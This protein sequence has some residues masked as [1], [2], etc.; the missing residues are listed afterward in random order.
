MKT[1]FIKKQQPL[2]YSLFT[3]FLDTD[4]EGA[5]RKTVDKAKFES[6]LEGMEDLM[7]NM[8]LSKIE[9]DF[10]IKDKDLIRY[11]KIT[12]NDCWLQNS[13]EFFQRTRKLK[14]KLFLSR[15]YLLREYEGLTIK[16]DIYSD[17][18]VARESAKRYERFQSSC[19]EGKINLIQA[20][21][22]LKEMVTHQ[23][24][25]PK[26]ALTSCMRLEGAPVD[27][28]TCNLAPDCTV[29]SLYP[30]AEHYSVTI[31]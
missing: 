30:P 6:L 31:M 23:E 5:W 16:R 25:L 22:V 28:A 15:Y 9:G 11:C 17:N 20:I 29:L 12:W 21:S 14:E 4:N 2:S 1:R 7:K 13:N 27:R 19:Q 26:C 18:S 8:D 24:K 10:E 3:S